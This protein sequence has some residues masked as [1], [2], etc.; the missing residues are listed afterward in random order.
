MKNSNSIHVIGGGLAGSEAAWQLASF[1]IPVTIHEMRP[2]KMTEVHKTE[3]FSELVCSNSF[4]SD[5]YDNNAV[6]LLHQELRINKSLIMHCADQ[7]KIPAG[8]A[9]AVDRNKFSSLV[10]EKILNHNL[11]TINREEVKDLSCFSS[12]DIIL[13]STGPLTSE[14]LANEII[15]NTGQNS[16][17]FFDAIAPIIYFDSIDMSKAWFQSRYDKGDGKDYINCPLNK[18]QYFNFVEQLI[19]STKIEFKEWEKNTPYFEGCMPIEVMA[20]RG[21]ETLRHGP[22]K[23]FGL[24]NSNGPKN[25]PYAVIQLRQDNSLGSLWNIVGFQT[26][27]TYEEQKRVF[28]TIPGLENAKFARLGGLHRNTFINSPNLLCDELNLKKS[29]NIYFAG[30]IT[31]VEGY[32]ESCAIGLL[33]GLFISFQRRNKK[34]ILPPDETAL[35]S[36]LKHVT[37]NANK[38]TFQPMNINFGLFPNL[39]NDKYK[40]IDKRLKRNFISQNAIS[41]ITEWS[42][43]INEIIK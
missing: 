12:E 43:I 38:D 23:P 37:K 1:N 24:T 33:A 11:I 8:G 22:M 27:M 16:L 41:K 3:N 31:G 5:D 20:E 18:E 40:K 25:K 6:G 28:K 42:N 39:S 26:K 17:A 13:I 15:S 2:V 7:S 21:V 29:P 14:S 35:G 32:V 34:I 19:K 36:L 30:Q 9:L 4:R 10:S